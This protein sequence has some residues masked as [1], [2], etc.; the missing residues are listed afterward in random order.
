MRRSHRLIVALAAALVATL[1]LAPASPASARARATCPTLQVAERYAAGALE[2]GAYAVSPLVGPRQP[3]RSA[4]TVVQSYLYDPPSF[5]FWHVRRLRGGG[6]RFRAPTGA[7]FTTSPTSRLVRAA[8]GEPASTQ[9]A[10]TIA[11]TQ[12]C[13]YFTVVHN[14]SAVGFPAGTYHRLNFSPNNAG[15][16]CSPPMPDSYDL[17][18]DYLLDGSVHGYGVGPLTGSLAKNPGCRFLKTG[19]TTTGFDVWCDGKGS[20]RGPCVT[21]RPVPANCGGHY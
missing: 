16:H 1:S 15:L 4:E 14:D 21:A 20:S 18:R 17:L 9:P 13:P 8:S 2:A 5:R 6:L 10:A 7:S 11:A 19:T 3:C 12:T